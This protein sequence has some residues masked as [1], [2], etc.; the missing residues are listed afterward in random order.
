LCHPSPSART[1]SALAF[2]SVYWVL[3]SS[4]IAHAGYAWL[5]L[6]GTILMCV[7]AALGLAYSLY[8]YVVLNKLTI[9]ESAAATSSLM[10]VFWGIVLEVPTIAAYTVF[11]YSVFRCKATGLSYGQGE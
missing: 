9:W 8:P 11:V 7:I 4:R 2:F 5:V 6:A 10:F 1:S 3:Y